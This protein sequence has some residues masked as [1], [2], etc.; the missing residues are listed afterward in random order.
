MRR[1]RPE[2]VLGGREREVFMNEEEFTG[3]ID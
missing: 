3:Q 2:E 1:S